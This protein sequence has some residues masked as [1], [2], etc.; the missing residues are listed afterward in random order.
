MLRVLGGARRW[1]PRRAS[2]AAR[3][4]R[5]ELE[6]DWLSGRA[7]LEVADRQQLRV[8]SCALMAPKPKD[9]AYSGSLTDADKGEILADVAAK[10]KADKEVAAKIKADKTSAELGI[11]KPAASGARAAQ[12]AAV[13]RDHQ[14][15]EL[16]EAH[17]RHRRR[18]VPA[19]VLEGEE[20]GVLQLRGADED[21]AAARVDARKVLH[22][23]DGLSS[24]RA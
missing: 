1:T 18:R 2:V 24:E 10:K 4:M 15:G 21:A 17:P 7:Q 9:K 19:E 20:S 14:G 3:A 11:K 22:H 12:A 16:R 23:Q 5:V 13:E 8:K 6:R